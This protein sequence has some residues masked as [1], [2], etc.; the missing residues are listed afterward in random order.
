MERATRVIVPTQAVA[1]AFDVPYSTAKAAELHLARCLA[2]EGGAAGIRV[3]S[4]NPDA[5]LQGSKI[6]DDLLYELNH[7]D[8]E[9]SLDFQPSLTREDSG[10]YDQGSVEIRV[11]A[12]NKY[13]AGKGPG[14]RDRRG[15]RI[16][17]NTLSA[18]LRLSEGGKPLALFPGDLDEIGLAN[19]DCPAEDLNAPLLVFPHHGGR[20]GKKGLDDVQRD[21][22]FSKINPYRSCLYPSMKP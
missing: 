19:L 4:V 3:N 12:P 17:T 15:R 10:A 18:V 14:S 8:Q 9:G 6:W 20:V 11:L 21:Q 5:V 22:P 1:E 2:E 7:L 16:R 13:L